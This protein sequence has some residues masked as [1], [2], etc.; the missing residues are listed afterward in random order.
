MLI[1]LAA[2]TLM[3]TPTEWLSPDGPADRRPPCQIPVKDPSTG[4]TACLYW[5]H[6]ERWLAAHNVKAQTQ[7]STAMVGQLQGIEATRRAA[8]AAAVAATPSGQCAVGVTDPEGDFLCAVM[9][10]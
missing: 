2:A 7:P 8:I 6:Y 3:L 10:P 1:L 4:E 9:A 5:G